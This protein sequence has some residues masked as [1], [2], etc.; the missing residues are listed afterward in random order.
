MN[1]GERLELLTEGFLQHLVSP[2]YFLFLKK[3]S[4]I[5]F[6]IFLY[7]CRCSACMYI[8]AP[9]VCLVL[10]KIKR[11]WSLQNW[12]WSYRCSWMLGIK[13]HPSSRKAASTPNC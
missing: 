10:A 5:V 9:G 4:N 12:S 1:S 11:C 6:I 8:S 13:P 7:V 2:E 3:K